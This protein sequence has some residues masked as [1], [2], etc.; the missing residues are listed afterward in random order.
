[1]PKTFS[2]Y[3]IDDLYGYKN[4][5]WSILKWYLLC[6]H[7]LFFLDSVSTN[8]ILCTRTQGIIIIGGT[9]SIHCIQE[10]LKWFL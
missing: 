2:I 7:F 3:E 10:A 4:H 5:K 8:I 1:M 6:Q 9:E